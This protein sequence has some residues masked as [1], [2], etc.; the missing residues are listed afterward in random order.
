MYGSSNILWQYSQRA[1]ISYDYISVIT[2][3]MS[4]NKTAYAVSSGK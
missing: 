2:E 1:S 4:L 3:N